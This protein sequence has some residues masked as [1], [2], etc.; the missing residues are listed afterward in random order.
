MAFLRLATPFVIVSY[1]CISFFDFDVR[2][3]T[4][5]NYSTISY[6]LSRIRMRTHRCRI[7]CCGERE[8]GRGRAGLKYRGSSL[9]G[10]RYVSSRKG[11]EGLALSGAESSHGALN[12]SRR[13]RV[14]YYCSNIHLFNS[15]VLYYVVDE[16]DRK[17]EVSTANITSDHETKK[18]NLRTSR[19]IC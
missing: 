12:F 3:V 11:S 19:I 10:P 6:K 2:F 4:R 5:E 15:L 17:I 8:G 1:L 13:P 9:G 7:V 18:N 14:Q 16:N